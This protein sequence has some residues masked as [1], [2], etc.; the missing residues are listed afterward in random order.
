MVAFFGMIVLFLPVV[1]TFLCF[2]LFGKRLGVSLYVG[3]GLLL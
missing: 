3:G 1:H 2:R